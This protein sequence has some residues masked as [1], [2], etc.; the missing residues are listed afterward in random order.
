QRRVEALESKVASLPDARQIDERIKAN[1]P[2]P[3]DPTQPPTFKDLA[4]P[5]PDVD[6]IVSTARTTWALVEVFAEIKLMLWMLLDRRYHMGW[7]TRLAAIGLVIAF[8]LSYLWVPFGGYDNFVSRMIGQAGDLVL[9]LILFMVLMF[10]TRRY[11]EWRKG[12]S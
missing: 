4:L 11:K 2:P 1:L 6:T 3:V 9:G 10:E 7:L 8:M 5:I 12:R